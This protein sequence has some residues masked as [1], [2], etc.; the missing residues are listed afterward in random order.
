MRKKINALFVQP[1]KRIK[2]IK[3]YGTEEELSELVGGNYKLTFPVGNGVCF[4]HKKLGEYQVARANRV[5]ISKWGMDDNIICGNIVIL[6]CDEVTCKF[7]SLTDFE[8][9]YC[10]EKYDKSHFADYNMDVFDLVPGAEIS[11]V[12]RKDSIFSCPLDNGF[13][14]VKIIEVYP[15]FIR[16][17]GTTRFEDKFEFC[18]NKSDLICGDTQIVIRKTKEII[19]R[20][21]NFNKI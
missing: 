13:E 18:I 17:E 7:R 15:Y 3:I 21:D 4:V 14:K 5:T 12:N 10:I 1:G 8:Y 2:E 9:E 6:G 20:R 19:G 16:C 11:F